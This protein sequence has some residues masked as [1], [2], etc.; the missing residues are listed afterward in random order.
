MDLSFSDF[1]IFTL[2]GSSALVLFFAVVSRT[3]HARAESRS[4]RH[5]VVCRLCLRAFENHDH[6]EL[7]ICPACGATNERGRSRRLG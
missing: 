1:V 6:S 7:V 5:R 2:V 3:L 4:L